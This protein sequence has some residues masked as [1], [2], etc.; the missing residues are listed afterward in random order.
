MEAAIERAIGM[1]AFALW[2]R[3]T[4]TLHL[5]RDRLGIKP[6][7]YA[8]TPERVL[9]AS[10]L[11]AFRAV[12][13]WKPTIDGDAVA[14]FLR[15]GYIAQPRTI[16]RE[17]AKLPPGHILTLRPGRSPAA[18][19]LLGPARHRHRRQARNDPAPDENEAV[20]RLDALLRDSVGCG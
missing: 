11:K 1:F 18:E 6:L 9:F 20:E 10:E 5:V 4:R 16:Y 3:S 12:P 13:G 7:Y 8:A 17:A 19:V 2:D 14:G 15:H